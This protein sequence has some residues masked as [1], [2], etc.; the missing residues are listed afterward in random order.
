MLGQIK[1]H[2]FRVTQT[3]L[4]LLVKSRVFFRFSGKKYID[5]YPFYVPINFHIHIDTIMM[6][7]S[8]IY[9]KGSQIILYVCSC[10]LFLFLSKQSLKVIKHFHA[11]LN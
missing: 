5:V 4:N 2:V 8:I 6:G 1:E 11:Q 10:K 3:Y 7:F 9:F